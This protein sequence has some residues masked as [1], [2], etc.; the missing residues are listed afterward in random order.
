MRRAFRFELLSEGGKNMLMDKGNPHGGD[1]YGRDIR[2][3]FSAN[4]NP[5]GTPDSVK[6]A[7]AESLDALSFYPDAYCRALRAA[8]SGYEGVPCEHIIC[9]NGAAELIY[10]F[11][12]AV[13]GT[14]LIASPTFSEYETAWRAA[15]GEVIRYPLREENGFYPDDGFLAHI[16]EKTS[17]VFLC[18][19]NNP[20]GVLYDADFIMAAAERCRRVGARLFL[21]CCFLDLSDDPAGYAI[22]ALIGKF[23]NVFVLRAFTKS[24]GM[25]GLRLGY[26]L[27]SDTALLTRMAEKAPCWNISSAAQAAGIAAVADK[28]TLVRFRALISEERPYL[29]RA[30]SDF[31]FRVYDGAA[32]FL[33][34]RTD[35]P[36]YEALLARGIQIR[37]C[38]NF[39]GLDGRYFRTAVREHS[40]NEILVQTIREMIT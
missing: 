17:A 14:A 13:G 28:D 29:S 23:P 27:C 36:L 33:L 6:R 31:G 7:V 1:R 24:Y 39:A 19:P 21:D 38:A 4:V 35:M 16:G 11:A 37:S 9:G 30:L 8:L 22:P 15:G 34:F 12:Y 10:S 18:T 3:D 20:T 2:I 32:N 40:D 26:G 25:A 5:F